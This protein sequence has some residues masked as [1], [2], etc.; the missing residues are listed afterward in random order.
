MKRLLHKKICPRQWWKFHYNTQRY[1]NQDQE[2]EV[3][4]KLNVEERLRLSW[5]F[6]SL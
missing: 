1:Y 2:D 3:D 4:I 5:E 6:Q